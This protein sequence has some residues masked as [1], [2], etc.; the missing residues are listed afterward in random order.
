MAELTQPHPLASVIIPVYNAE[1]TLRRCVESIV[2]QT[3]TNWE[4]VLV[5]DGSTDGCGAICDEFAARDSRIRVIHKPNEG[6]AATRNLGIESARG[7]YSIQIDADDWVEP[8]MLEELCDA[9]ES[10]GADMV[11]CDYYI[12]YA[13]RKPLR[14]IQQKPSEMTSSAVL[15]D[16]LGAG[17]LRPYCW[18]RLVR[19]ECYEKYGVVIPT[20]ISHGEDFLLC[21][22]L[23]RHAE[24][25]VAYVP[26]AFYHYV[27]AEGCNLL[28]RTYTHHDF[29]RDE[30]LVRH[31]VAMMDGHH[32]QRSVEERAVFHL[33]RRAFN[34]GIFT[35]TEFKART[36]GYRNIIKGNRS[37]AWHRRWR[38]HLSCIGL[39]GPM[40]GYKKVLKRKENNK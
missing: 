14:H 27:Q 29:E 28:T 16:M 40:R 22:Q 4:L 37:I 36:Y 39:Y 34:G 11:L 23:L 3:L 24:L 13:G 6:V 2:A 33:V 18:S 19:H 32:E 20:D 12:D 35:P 5:N 31:G 9:A 30:R 10:K 21:L 8:T 25:K 26:K 38:L 17:R 1:L 15:A 7:R